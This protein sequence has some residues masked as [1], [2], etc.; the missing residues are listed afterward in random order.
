MTK[1][2]SARRA[3]RQWFDKTSFEN[4]TVRNHAYWCGLHIEML[5]MNKGNVPSFMLWNLMQGLRELEEM[6]GRRP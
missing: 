2:Q 1:L 3:Y 6:L 4:S 5:A